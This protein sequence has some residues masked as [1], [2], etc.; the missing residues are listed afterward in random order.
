MGSALQG[1]G[2]G[3][4]GGATPKNQGAICDRGGDC[5]FYKA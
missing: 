1:G 5:P 4:G 2:E 3:G